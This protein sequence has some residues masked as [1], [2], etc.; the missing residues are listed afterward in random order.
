MSDLF[1]AKSDEEIEEILKSSSTEE[2]LSIGHKT[3]DKMIL[4]YAIENANTKVWAYDYNES[5][6]DF[7][8][9][10]NTKQYWEF[11]EIDEKR[12]VIIKRI[13]DGTQEEYTLKFFADRFTPIYPDNRILKETR[14]TLNKI[15][16]TF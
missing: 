12:Y 2:L 11:I 8:N 4:L 16:K 15:Y 1:K 6:I 10:V 5:S 14:N 13:A 3:N 9:A 7:M